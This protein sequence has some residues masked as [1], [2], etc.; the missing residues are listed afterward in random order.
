MHAIAATSQWSMNLVPVEGL[1]LSDADG[2]C[3]ENKP[4]PSQLRGQVPQGAGA[5]HVLAQVCA[6]VIRKCRE[7][8]L[9]ASGLIELLEVLVGFSLLDQVVDESSKTRLKQLPPL[10]P[11]HQK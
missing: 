10:V 5:L 2:F 1:D 11:V 7:S 6:I 3:W 9:R 8:S 4:N